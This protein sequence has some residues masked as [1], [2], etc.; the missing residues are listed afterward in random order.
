MRFR[1]AAL[2]VA[3]ASLF[4]LQSCS[5]APEASAAGLW[6]QTDTTGKADG[7]FLVAEH[8]GRYDVRLVKLFSKP[9]AD[10][11]PLC[12]KC[13]GRQRDASWLGLTVV[14]GMRR[15]GFDYRDG[16]ILDP[17]NGFKFYGRMQLSPDG[18]ALTVRG[19]LG[20][21]PLGGS[22]VWRRLPDSAYNELDPTV[23]AGHARG[24]TQD[25]RTPA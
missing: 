5:R 9:G 18:Q 19:Y 7:W 1:L 8:D 3:L 23:A 13:V 22:D 12:T 11:N 2:V 4:C 15:N 20:I 6:E 16:T 17:R 10:P 21:E 14:E 24:A 25:G